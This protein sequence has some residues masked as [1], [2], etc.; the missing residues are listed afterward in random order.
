M[1]VSDIL[2][3]FMDRFGIRIMREKTYQRNIRIVEIEV[4]GEAR[5][6]EILRKQR[7]AAAKYRKA[8][9][10][11]SEVRLIS[12]PVLGRAHVFYPAKYQVKFKFDEFGGEMKIELGFEDYDVSISDIQR[13]IQAKICGGG[14]DE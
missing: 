10:I 5:R 4:A 8:P 6:A 3:A 12:A 9:V 2:D 13:A 14:C 1:S 7:K 11:I